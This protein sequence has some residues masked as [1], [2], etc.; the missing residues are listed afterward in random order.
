MNE[1][2]GGWSTAL[3]LTAVS[4]AMHEPWRW[5]G[6]FLGR[7]LD[8]QSEVFQWVRAVATALVAGLV[9][10]LL[11]FPAG[12]LQDVPLL[13]RLAAFAA[14][15]AGFHLLGRK[16]APGVAAG[17]LVLVAGSLLVG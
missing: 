1:L 12:A 3:I 14:G 8:V 2:Q 7:N 17:A 16:L 4:L 15:I 11:L 13:V 10:R 9:M 5:I 6:L